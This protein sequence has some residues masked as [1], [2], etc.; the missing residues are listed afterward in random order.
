MMRTFTTLCVVFFLLAMA[1][2]GLSPIGESTSVSVSVNRT[3]AFADYSTPVTA[4][5]T[6]TRNGSATAGLPVSFNLPSD[7]TLIS[8]ATGLSTDSNGQ[9]TVRFKRFPTFSNSSTATVTAQ[10][11]SITS[12]AQSVA[13]LRPSVGT[14]LLTISPDATT[15]GKF[16]FQGFGLGS[17][18]GTGVGGIGVTIRYT[19]ALAASLVSFSPTDM[20]AITAV[21]TNTP[22]EIAFSGLSSTAV[23]EFGTIATIAF[24]AGSGVTITG[25]TVNSLTDASTSVTPL[26]SRTV[27]VNP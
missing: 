13:F 24:P 14:N 1:A 21:N 11:G 19:P 20:F 23:A 2:C 5:A 3:S 8:P 12:S 17:T 7:V 27:I 25:M 4:T 18:S 9:A 22:G 15:S 10:S 6:V 26:S 16:L